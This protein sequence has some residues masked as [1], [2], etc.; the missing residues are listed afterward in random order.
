MKFSKYRAV[1]RN[2][3]I[4]RSAGQVR[5][6]PAAA[7]DPTEQSFYTTETRYTPFLVRGV[8]RETSKMCIHT[9]TNI[10]TCA[11]IRARRYIRIYIS[12][13]SHRARGYVLHPLKPYAR[14]RWRGQVCRYLTLIRSAWICICIRQHRASVQREANDRTAGW[15]GR[16]GREVPTGTNYFASLTRLLVVPL[17]ITSFSLPFF[18]FRIISS[19]INLLISINNTVSP[20][21]L[22][23]HLPALY[24]SYLNTFLCI[25]V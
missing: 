15:C 9:C 24:Y 6:I 12:I 1:A 3:E 14:A 4:K 5:S 2:L 17:D 19:I 25:F 8:I 22:L 7:G 13:L 21:V 10:H 16:G 23:L 11:H 20:T 18:P